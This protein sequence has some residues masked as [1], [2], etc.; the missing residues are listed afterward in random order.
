MWVCRKA[1]PQSK[2]KVEN[3]VKFIKSS[4][5]SARRFSAVSEIEE[6]LR[7]WLRRRAN[8]QP[9][10]ATSRIPSEVLESEERTALRPLRASLFERE[11]RVLRDQRQA[12]P[13][14][15]ISVGGNRYSVPMAYRRKEVEIY[16]TA[17]QLFIYDA[18]SGA[19][20][21]HHE[22]SMLVGQ[23]VILQGHAAPSGASADSLFASLAAT[24]Q[25]AQWPL[26][27]QANRQR[28]PRYWKE[29]YALSY[30]RGECEP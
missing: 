21:A 20:V 30:T 5:F 17:E 23:T 11:R 26:F 1:D 13:K 9:C 10:Q 2:G 7:N 22:L 24:Y 8:G 6:P 19:E 25:F 27:L 28:Y 16:T 14:G 29:Q 3:T 15:L 4:F 18:A 12:C